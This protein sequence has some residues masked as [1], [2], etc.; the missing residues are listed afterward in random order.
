M[1]DFNSESATLRPCERS[2][3]SMSAYLKFFALE[4]SPFEGKAGSQI[5]LGTR[6]LR[7][8][9]AAIETGLAEG[10]SRICVSG[11]SGLGKTSLARALPKLLGDS[12][13]V[14]L[15]ADP[16]RSWESLRPALARQ[17][18]IETGGL[19]RDNLL[20]A[21]EHDRLV[22]VIDQAERADEEFLDHLDVV[23]SYRDELGEPV[24]QSVLLAC[25]S[26]VPGRDPAPLLWWLDRIQTLQLEF[27]PL[28]REGVGSYIA[29]HLKRAGWGGDP[30]FS[31]QA[32]F[33]IHEHCDGIPGRISA[34]CEQLLADAAERGIERIELDFVRARCETRANDRATSAG[35]SEVDA[36]AEANAAIETNERSDPTTPDEGAAHTEGSMSGL[37]DEFEELA[38]EEEFNDLTG[39]GL[40]WQAEETRPGSDPAPNATPEPPGAPRDP[41]A[42]RDAAVAADTARTDSGPSLRATLEFFRSE[43]SRAPTAALEASGAAGED[44]LDETAETDAASRAELDLFQAARSENAPNRA[45]ASAMYE[46]SGGDESAEGP[47]IETAPAADPWARPE[48]FDGDDPL[49]APPS[50]AELR[51]I[52]GGFGARHLGTFA[53]AAILAIVGGLAFA[54]FSSPRESAKTEREAAVAEVTGSSTGPAPDTSSDLD[55]ASPANGSPHPRTTATSQSTAASDPAGS[56]DPDGVG[57]DPSALDPSLLAPSRTPEALVGPGGGF[58]ATPETKPET[59]ASEPG[60]AADASGDRGP[61][62]AAILPSGPPSDD[63]AR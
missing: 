40:D 39:S 22:I 53:G 15:V 57:I 51:A 58:V 8:A 14:A 54:L 29:K 35:S 46:Q 36:V 13:R 52:R 62:P 2:G 28:P 17:W 34:L 26:A 9:F 48:R 38:L 12:A 50:E 43:P 27:A 19:A 47:F 60:A 1:A 10:A 37:V 3:N 11:K 49:W 30:L 16:D 24:V 20:R 45:R 25:L 23:L 18:G 4:Q 5:V 42:E 32:A 41:E 44:G 7:D 33:A 55:R 21:A 59:R 31:E 61:V 6:A 56:G 63:A